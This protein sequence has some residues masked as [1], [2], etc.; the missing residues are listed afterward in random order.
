MPRKYCCDPYRN[1]K[2]NIHK[3]IR[4]VS[5]SM[6]E[7]GIVKTGEYICNNCRQQLLAIQP[8]TSTAADESLT[9][10]SE[11]A[12]HLTSESEETSQECTEES[13]QDGS[14]ESDHEGL[15]D[16]TAPSMLA[17]VLPLIGE[18]PIKKSK[19]MPN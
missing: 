6:I 18:S 9:G 12:E 1:H 15:L 2:T 19:F 11:E 16:L 3:N 13:S 4:T 5:E 8:S 7:T 17:T 10:L 14:E